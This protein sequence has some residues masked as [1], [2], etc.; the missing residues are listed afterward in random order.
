MALWNRV[1]CQGYKETNTPPCKNATKNNMILN[2]VLRQVRL[3]L[4][5]TNLITKNYFIRENRSK[6]ALNRRE[7]CEIAIQKCYIKNVLASLARIFSRWSS[8]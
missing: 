8:F 6:H 5:N 1:E 2:F 3:I 7:L 4:F